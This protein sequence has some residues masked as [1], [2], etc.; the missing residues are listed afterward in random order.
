MEIKFPF[1]SYP[2]FIFIFFKPN[3]LVLF[4]RRFKKNNLVFLMTCEE[5]KF[6]PT[7]G[8]RGQW[9]VYYTSSQCFIITFLFVGLTTLGTIVNF[10]WVVY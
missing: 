6:E 1:Q 10:D 5:F 3:I 4:R 7:Q 9:A 8:E 2:Y